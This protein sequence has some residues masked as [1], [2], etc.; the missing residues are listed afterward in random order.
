VG[1]VTEIG[2]APSALQ[3]GP[4]PFGVFWRCSCGGKEVMGKVIRLLRQQTR[5]QDNGSA[6][7]WHGRPASQSAASAGC[8]AA[9]FIKNPRQIKFCVPMQLHL[10]KQAAVFLS[11]V[12]AVSHNRCHPIDPGFQRAGPLLRPVHPMSD[13]Q[14]DYIIIGGGTA[15]PCWPTA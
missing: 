9:I 3:H 1:A 8:G 2:G 12:Q 10:Y 5:P 14:F 15:A 11:T 7:P 4:G 6:A 13:N